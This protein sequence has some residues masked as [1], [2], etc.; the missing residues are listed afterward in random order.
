MV[1]GRI[2]SCFDGVADGMGDRKDDST[3]VIDGGLGFVGDID[4]RDD[5][6]SCFVGMFTLFG[7]THHSSIDHICRFQQLE[8]STIQ[9][10]KYFFSYSI[11]AVVKKAWAKAETSAE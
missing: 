10:Q 9:N 5:R 7:S 6:R 1:E 11:N 4:N 8:S 3:H 2:D